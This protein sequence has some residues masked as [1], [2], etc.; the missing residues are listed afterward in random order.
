MKKVQNNFQKG[1]IRYIVFKEN[2]SFYAVGLELNIVVDGTTKETALFGLFDAMKGYIESAKK[3]NLRPRILNQ[4]AEDEYE[5]LWK[6]LNS[7]KPV[8]SPFQV[9]TFGRQLV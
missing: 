8:E 7:N 5:E 3:A 6:N 1:S 9:A 2:D 4:K